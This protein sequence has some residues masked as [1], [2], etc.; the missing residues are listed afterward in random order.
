MLRESPAAPVAEVDPDAANDPVIVD[1][2][3][4]TGIT[5]SGQTQAHG[6]IPFPELPTHGHGGLAPEAAADQA[7]Q[8]ERGLHIAEQS[9]DLGLPPAASN[10]GGSTSASTSGQRT[11]PKPR[12]RDGGG[13]L[14]A[15]AGGTPTGPAPPAAAVKQP[16]F[17]RMSEQVESSGRLRDEANRYLLAG[18]N[19]QAAELYTEAI[20]ALPHW[21]PE[22][23]V[24]LANRSAALLALGD[25]RGA[26][27]DAELAVRHD[28]LYFKGHFRLAKA[29]QA[30]ADAAERAAEMAA[31][32]T[33][34]ATTATA[35]VTAAV[36]ASGSQGEERRGEAAQHSQEAE[37]AAAAAAAAVAA[38]ELGMGIGGSPATLREAAAEALALSLAIKKNAAGDRAAQLLDKYW[39]RIVSETG[40]VKGMYSMRVRAVL[41]APSRMCRHRKMAKQCG[42]VRVSERVC[43]YVCA[44][45]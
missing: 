14:P 18:Q 38:A 22:T 44:C 25:A 17:S 8:A 16:H 31:K 41:R 36:V 30:L 15:P 37:A 45:V 6:S 7:A 23:A 12:G 21:A 28:C 5:G 10:G 32:A 19:A 39:K 33:A 20:K 43:V 2:F 35:T 24:C 4:H 3:N 27:R 40:S 11:R 9:E 13:P 42:V 1:V 26:R 34:A 29:L